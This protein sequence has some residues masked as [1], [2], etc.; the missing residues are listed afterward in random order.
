LETRACKWGVI[1]W[2]GS[3]DKALSPQQLVEK[4]QAQGLPIQG[5]SAAEK[6]LRNIGV[7]RLK[8]YWSHLLDPQTKTFSSQT[9][10]HVIR[11]YNF[12]SQLRELTF[13]ALTQAEVAFRVSI[14]ETMCQRHGPHW[15]LNP[16]NFSLPDSAERRQYWV[17]IQKIYTTFTGRERTV[18][19]ALK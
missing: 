10:D 17:L 9:F 5:P 3:Q 1:L 7:Y 6:A 2:F 14:S 8:G 12:D 11:R 4:L 18:F 13:D 15:Y 19:L 16:A